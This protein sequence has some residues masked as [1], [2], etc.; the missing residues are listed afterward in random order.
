M[1]VADSARL[2]AVLNARSVAVVGASG[3]EARIGG[4]PV[5]A[6]LRAGFAGSVYPVNPRYREVFGIPCYP[7]LGSLPGR[8]DLVVSA[9][10]HAATLEV[11]KEAP[12]VGAGA[13]VVFASGYREVGEEGRLL[14]AELSAAAADAGVELIGPN[15]LGILSTASG[16]MAS[17]TATLESG[18]VPPGSAGFVC[19]SGAFGSYFLAMARQRHL[20]VRYW[21]ATGNEASV[22]VA[23]WI[24]AYLEDPEVAVVAGYLEGVSDPAKLLSV[25]RRAAEAGKP[26]VLLKTGRSQAGAR[27]ALSHTGAMVGDDRLFDAVLAGHGAYRARDLEELLDMVEAI[28]YRRIPTGKR[29]AILTVSGGVGILMADRAEE[30]G[31]SLDP[32]PPEL[33]ASLRALVPY[34]GLVNPI[35]FTG[36]FLSDASIAGS[37]FREIDDSGFYGSAIVFLGHTSLA[38][39]LALPAVE[40]ISATARSSAMATFIVGLATEPVARVL[41]DAGI[42]LMANP[43]R[44]VELVAGLRRLARPLPIPEEIAAVSVAGG[45]VLAETGALGALSA[46]GVGIPRFLVVASEQAAARA[47]AWFDS[48]VVIKASRSDLIHKSDSGAVVVGIAPSLCA[49]ELARM[50]ERI[51]DPELAVVVAEKVSGELELIVGALQTEF[52]PV[53]IVGPG[54]VLAEVAGGRVEMLVSRYSREAFLEELV[55][56][57]FGRAVLPGGRLHSPAALEELIRLV[58]T[59][60]GLVLGGA[61]EF[62]VNPAIWSVGDGRL[63]AVDALGRLGGDATTG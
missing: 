4:R 34:S 47:A 13:V 27:A 21:A 23:D 33:Q 9:V 58:E 30:V 49:G 59:V 62:E 37:F 26:V 43:V 53:V 51:G 2:L 45:G 5:A 52:G 17:F 28:G 7:D 54:G 42:M 60:S 38:E 32:P 8:A 20:G 22:S 39:S 44:A 1:A 29:D 31:L 35:D 19:Q 63:V 11:I 3:T 14:E 18:P 24:D 25:L 48:P 16:L 12:S 10:G 6:T 56:Q 50:R 40:V 57:G 46:S 15:C 41:R 61:V 55:A 36:Q